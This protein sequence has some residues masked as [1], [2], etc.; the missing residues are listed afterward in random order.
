VRAWALNL[1]QRTVGGGGLLSSPRGCWTRLGLAWPPFA[2]LTRPKTPHIPRHTRAN[3]TNQVKLHDPKVF[4]PEESL[5]T[6]VHL[7]QQL[8]SGP[9]KPDTDELCV[10]IDRTDAKSSNMVSGHSTATDGWAALCDFPISGADR[11]GSHR[12]PAY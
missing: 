11:I 5:K 6:V 12:S 1:K 7:Y 3:K 10:V 8:L 4:S 2:R 9:N